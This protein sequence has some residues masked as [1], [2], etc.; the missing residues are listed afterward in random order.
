MKIKLKKLQRTMFRQKKNAQRRKLEGEELNFFLTNAGFRLDRM[1]TGGML[2]NVL[3][4][5]KRINE[6]PLELIKE[7]D[8]EKNRL[9]NKKQK[10]EL[11]RTQSQTQSES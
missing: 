5:Q 4:E 10:R 9:L 8:S 3:E 6:E 2:S 11:R 1:R 7:M